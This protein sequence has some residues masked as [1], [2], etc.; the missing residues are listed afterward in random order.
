MTITDTPDGM[1]TITVDPEELWLLAFIAYNN[2]S[3]FEDAPER[4]AILHQMSSALNERSYE[5]N[6]R[7][8]L[9]VA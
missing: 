8:E 4:R 5:L 3:L 1:T 2:Y 9:G 7:E 6:E